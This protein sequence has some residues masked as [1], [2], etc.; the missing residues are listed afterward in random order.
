[1][2]PL[3]LYCLLLIMLCSTHAWAQDLNLKGKVLAETGMPIAGATISVKS[4]KTFISTDQNGE[5]ILKNI[6]PG[7]VLLI[8]CV[9]YDSQALSIT[10]NQL[11]TVTLKQH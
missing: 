5:F 11:L 1:M 6:R 4:G 3:K 8:T 2:K 7:A 9:G 10:G